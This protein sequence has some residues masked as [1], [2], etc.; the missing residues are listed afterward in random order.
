MKRLPLEG[1]EGRRAGEQ[2]DRHGAPSVGP[3]RGD[4]TRLVP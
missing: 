2:Q 3:S 4:V 1:R